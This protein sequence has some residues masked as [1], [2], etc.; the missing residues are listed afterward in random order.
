MSRYT[1]NYVEYFV[2]LR[3]NVTDFDDEPRHQMHVE[4]FGPLLNRTVPYDA[5]ENAPYREYVRASRARTI[6][7]KHFEISEKDATLLSQISIADAIRAAAATLPGDRS[8]TDVYMFAGPRAE[9]IE[10][11]IMYRKDRT[12]AFTLNGSIGVM[13]LKL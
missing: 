2:F 1:D 8:Y 10:T 7:H 13:T 9:T 5:E 4:R 6:L 3:N 11:M 12:V